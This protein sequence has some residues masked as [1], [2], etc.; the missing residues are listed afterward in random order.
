LTGHT[1]KALSD[2]VGIMKT[3]TALVRTFQL[4]SM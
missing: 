1:I 3:A 2:A 4:E